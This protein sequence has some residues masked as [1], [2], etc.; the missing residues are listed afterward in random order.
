MQENLRPMRLVI[1][2]PDK[3]I[4]YVSSDHHMSIA[5]LMLYS[6]IPCVIPDILKHMYQHAE[7][8]KYLPPN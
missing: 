7:I 8:D 1:T 5:L 6:G 2:G 4:E 3:W